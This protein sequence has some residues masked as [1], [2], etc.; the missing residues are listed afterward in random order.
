MKI[1]IVGSG[2]VG[3]TAAYAMLMS[4]IGR[5]IILVDKNRERAEAEAFDLNHAVPFAH[6]LRVY[7]GRYADLRNSRLVVI[8]AGVSQKPGESRLDLLK[9][10]ALVF[11][12]IIGEVLDSAPDTILLIATNPLDIMTSLADYYARKKGIGPGRVFGTGTMLD[13]ARFRSLLSEHTGVDSRHIHAYVLGEHGDSEVLTWSRVTVGGMKLDDFCS[14]NNIEM[15]PD[16]K[17]ELDS[18][19]RNAAYAIIRG[20][21]ATYYGIGS[22]LARLA[23]VILHDQRAILTVSAPFSNANEG[24]S[25]SMSMPHIVSGSGIINSIPL[26]LNKDEEELLKK[27]REVIASA[28]NELREYL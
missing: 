9:R 18:I 8:A 25:I 19:V 21:G 23:D 20:K 12:E 26:Q 10:N 28:L 4:G 15:G 7:P 14:F 27:S 2:M 5:E 16:K 6:P 24:L 3:S 11:S 17:A 13:T 22:A 1:G